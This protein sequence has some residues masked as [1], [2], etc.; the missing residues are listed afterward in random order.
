[1]WCY[2]KL[3]EGCY[4]IKD[5]THWVMEQINIYNVKFKTRLTF[6]ISVDSID[7]RSY[8]K[9][10]GILHLEI[11]HNIPLDNKKNLSFRNLCSVLEI[12]ISVL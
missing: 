8:I 7:F 12:T 6:D 2:I 9:W 10:N 1:M 3:Q 5:I 4:E 11:L